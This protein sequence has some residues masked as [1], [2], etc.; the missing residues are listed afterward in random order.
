MAFLDIYGAGEKLMIQFLETASLEISSGLPSS[1]AI[2][3]YVSGLEMR[4]VSD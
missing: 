3:Q 4:D 1:D 2:L